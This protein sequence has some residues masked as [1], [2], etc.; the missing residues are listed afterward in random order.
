[1]F[2]SQAFFA[3]LFFEIEKKDLKGKSKPL[4]TISFVFLKHD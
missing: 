3:C 4:K 2:F 1:M